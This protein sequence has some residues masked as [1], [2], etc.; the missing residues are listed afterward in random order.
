MVEAKMRQVATVAFAQRNWFTATE[1]MQGLT[2][3]P[4]LSLVQEWL[5]EQVDAGYLAT[6]RAVTVDGNCVPAFRV[7]R[8]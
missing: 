8:F 2:G 7:V 4:S 3:I 1:A 5:G 6:G